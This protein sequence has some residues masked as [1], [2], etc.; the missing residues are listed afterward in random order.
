VD[1]RVAQ[2]QDAA[3][4]AAVAAFPM[5]VR[6]TVTI[7]ETI[8]GLAEGQIQLVTEEFLDGVVGVEKA[9]NQVE[10]FRGDLAIGHVHLSSD[11]APGRGR[12]GDTGQP[13]YS[14]PGGGGGQAGEGG[15]ASREGKL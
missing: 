10:L 1:E 3:Q 14:T 9:L 4:K 7:D 12:G 15:M 13:G 2:A 5:A 8:E 6:V 11:G